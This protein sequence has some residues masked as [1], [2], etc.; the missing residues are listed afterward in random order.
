M[1]LATFAT[2]LATAI[3]TAFGAVANIAALQAQNA[4]NL[5]VRMPEKVGQTTH[6]SRGDIRD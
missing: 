4:K 6:L 5:A 3:P 2:L 1:K